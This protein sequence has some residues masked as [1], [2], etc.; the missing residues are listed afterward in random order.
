MSFCPNRSK[1][2]SLKLF[3]LNLNECKFGRE[4]ASGMISRLLSISRCLRLASKLGLF[5]NGNSKVDLHTTNSSSCNSLTCSHVF[6]G[7]KWQL[8][9]TSLMLFCIKIAR[10]TA[11]SFCRIS[12]LKI[13]PFLTDVVESINF[14]QSN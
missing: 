12:S 11:F 7:L 8:L 10:E 6:S 9:S 4:T 13:S 14:F 3:P 1:F 5:G 2:F